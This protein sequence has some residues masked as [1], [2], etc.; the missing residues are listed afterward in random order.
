MAAGSFARITGSGQS[1]PT[2]GYASIDYG[3]ITTDADSILSESSGVFTPQEEGFYLITAS[4]QF[5]LT[6]NNRVIIE[7]VIQKNSANV[8]GAWCS[9]Y[10]RNSS[11]DIVYGNGQLIAYFNGSSDTFRVQHRRDSG[12]GTPTGTYD[13]TRIEAVQLSAGDSDSLPYAHY[14]T[15]TTGTFG[16]S[17]FTTVTGWDVITENDTAT[18]ELQGDSSSIRL[19]DANRPYL[20]AYSANTTRATTARTGRIFQLRHNADPIRNSISHEYIRDSANQY[21]HPSSLALVKPT[22]ASQDLDLQGRGYW[23]N[24][25]TLWGTWSDGNWALNA[26]AGESGIMIIALPSGAD[27]AIFEDETANQTWN[28]TGLV[29]VNAFRTEVTAGT[30]FTRDNN[31]DVSVGSATDALAHFSVLAEKTASSGTRSNQS[32]R[33]EIE[34]VDQADSATD[35]LRGDQ[36]SQDHKNAAYTNSRVFSLSA[37]DTVQVEKHNQSQNSGNSDVTSYA[38]AFFIDLGTLDAGGGGDDHT[39]AP[40]EISVGLSTDLTTI[41]QNHIVVS[42]D[43][44]IA[45]TLDN[46]TIEE[47][48]PENYTASD[49]ASLPTNANDLSTAITLSDVDTDDNTYYET[50]GS[51]FVIHQFKY[52]HTN[53]TDDIEIT[54]RG[55]TSLA[56]STATVTLQIYNYNSTSWENLDTDSSTAADTEFVL[57]ATQSTNLANYYSSNVVAARVYQD[58][59]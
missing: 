10:G 8:A 53:S 59:S 43:I 42:D 2:T 4:W 34:G 32:V 55:R 56:P 41:N 37:N 7:Q 33:W 50:T 22:T 20:I 31:T 36:G 17:S 29:D 14:G 28:G 24:K 12:A 30:A 5:Q 57:T 13:Y 40:D 18:I 46:T 35:Y 9:G 3:S 52:T 51:N 19:K 1:V 54:W 23:D 39:L 44:S 15:P 49:E 26:S 38:G 21:G 27:V 16:G 48:T 6:H 58:M 45:Q 11:N 25:A 47:Q